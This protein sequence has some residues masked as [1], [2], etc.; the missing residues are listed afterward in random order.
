MKVCSNQKHENHCRDLMDKKVI[1]MRGEKRQVKNVDVRPPR[2]RTTTA[3][4]PRIGHIGITFMIKNL[5]VQFGKLRE[6]V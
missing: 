3:V 6:V 5:L 2:R 4:R 1:D